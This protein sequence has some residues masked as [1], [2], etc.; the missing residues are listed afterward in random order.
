MTRYLAVV[1]RIPIALVALLLMAAGCSSEDEP[2][3]VT[4]AGAA[5][6]TTS[7]LPGLRQELSALRARIDAAP[8]QSAVDELAAQVAALHEGTDWPAWCTEAQLP[9]V[10]VHVL[11]DHDDDG[12]ESLRRRTH[13]LELQCEARE[14]IMLDHHWHYI[15]DCVHDWHD[16]TTYNSDEWETAAM[17]QAHPTATRSCADPAYMHEG[18]GDVGRTM[19]L[20]PDGSWQEVHPSQ[21]PTP[22]TD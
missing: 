16:T 6:E 3:A 19:V 20:L 7:E 14:P 10:N 22:I 17:M 21:D 18:S 13:S 1:R 8:Q 5:P 2:P 9:Q 15:V 4:A 12:T 11:D